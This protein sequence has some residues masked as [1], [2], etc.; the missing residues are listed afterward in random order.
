MAHDPHHPAAPL[1]PHPHAHVAETPVLHDAPDEWHDHSHDEKPQHAHAEVGNARA[2]MSIGISLFLVIVFAC[3]A[4]Y[5]Y[6]MWFLANRLNQQEVAEAANPHSPAAKAITYKREALARLQD[7]G[8]FK[9]PALEPLPGQSFSQR[10][11][12]EAINAVAADYAKTPTT[13]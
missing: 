5:A 13:P 11:I 8:Q 3:V 2:I 4:V 9:L 10:K 7:G 1:H 6:Y 12:G